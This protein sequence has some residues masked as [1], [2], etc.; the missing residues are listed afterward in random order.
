MLLIT[1]PT[2]D[3]RTPTQVCFLVPH[4]P[5]KNTASGFKL[6][7]SLGQ[8][9]M[10]VS[11]TASASCIAVLALVACRSEASPA[12]LGSR[13]L[14]SRFEQPQ[15][16]EKEVE[17]AEEELKTAEDDAALEEKNL[18]SEISY[19]DSLRSQEQRD[20]SAA[21]GMINVD[22]EAPGCSVETTGDM[23]VATD[24]TDVL[25]TVPMSISISKR[26]LSVNYKGRELKPVMKIPLL[27]IKTPINTLARSRRCFR[28]FHRTKPLVFCADDTAARDEW[29]AN[30]YKAVFC[31]NSGNLLTP[32][33]QKAKRE[34]G[35]SVPLPSKSTKVQRWIKEI[36]RQEAE[37]LKEVQE[38][39]MMHRKKK[40]VVEE[41]EIVGGSAGAPPKVTVN[42][43]E[44]AFSHAG[45][46]EQLMN[47]NNQEF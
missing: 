23:D 40:N 24:P 31:I 17:D 43:D 28:L 2:P 12:F 16:V 8:E 18:E 38:G 6:R 45:Q 36:A 30:I 4:C 35:E 11:A 9:T 22:A 20:E 46:R 21:K 25:T 15:T 7:L 37:A 47:A 26:H 29:I 41:V 27:E 10:K 33:Q 34:K 3:S 44:L 42:G 13:G 1:F 19:R 39:E 14:G 32:V 5:A